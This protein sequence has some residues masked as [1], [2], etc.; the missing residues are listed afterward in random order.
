MSPAFC[1]FRLKT[2]LR[3]HDFAIE[4]SEL[5]RKTENTNQR[6]I[7]SALSL[8]L[9]LTV[10]PWKWIRS[11]TVFNPG[12]DRSIVWS[13]ENAWN[14]GTI[15]DGLF[16]DYSSPV[17]LPPFS[18]D[19]LWTLWSL[20]EGD[21]G[22]EFPYQSGVGCRWGTPTCWAIERGSL[23]SLALSLGSSPFVDRNRA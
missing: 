21:P 2:P 16:W 9:I 7:F 17:S 5:R 4:R 23:G 1:V 22:K 19:L 18:D 6:K 13:A 14:L 3:N 15:C 10:V 11:R 12:H 8:I 20:Q